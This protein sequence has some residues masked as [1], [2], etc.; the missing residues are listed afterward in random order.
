VTVFARFA[1]ELPEREQTRILVLI[2][3]A[4]GKEA[5]RLYL[6]EHFCADPECDCRRVMLAVHGSRERLATIM[7]DFVGGADR[8]PRGEHPYLEP[9]IEQPNR[10]DEV[11][12]YVRTELD[13]DAAYRERLVRHYEEMK[14]RMRDPAHPLGPAILE[15]PRMMTRV[16]GSLVRSF[17]PVPAG[18]SRER[19]VRNRRKR[20]RKRK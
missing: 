20:R 6:D 4:S 3:R 12:A 19:R 17:V 8:T 7:Y 13:G 1:D 15:D 2:D 5:A 10:A 16:A 9:G 11:L 18:P 14:E